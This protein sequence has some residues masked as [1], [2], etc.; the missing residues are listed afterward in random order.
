MS[1]REPE[2][3]SFCTLVA[4]FRSRCTAATRIGCIPLAKRVFK[5]LILVRVARPLHFAQAARNPRRKRKR[6]LNG[7]VGNR[8]RHPSRACAPIPSLSR[9]QPPHVGAHPFCASRRARCPYRVFDRPA[10]GY[11]HPPSPERGSQIARSKR[12]RPVFS[13]APSTLSTVVLIWF[14]LH[15]LPLYVVVV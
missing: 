8:P 4:R 2:S 11:P 1:R 7:P 3:R 9:R 6:R 5:A 13:T 10:C 14:L 15:F 12:C